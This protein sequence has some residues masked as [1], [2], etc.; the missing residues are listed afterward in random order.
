MTTFQRGERVGMLRFS[1]RDY[2][3]PLR[4]TVDHIRENGYYAIRLDHPNPLDTPHTINFW[5]CLGSELVSLN[6]E[7]LRGLWYD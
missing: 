6:T 2:N 4:G 7:S 1:M 3:P 5:P